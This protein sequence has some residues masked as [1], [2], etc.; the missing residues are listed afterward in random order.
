MTGRTLDHY[1][2]LEQIGI[3]GAGEVYRAIDE[4][5]GCPVAI[6]MPILPL[7][8]GPMHPDRLRQEGRVLASLRHPNICALRGAGRCDGVEY[9]VMELLEGQTLRAWMKGRPL[10]GPF[11][12]RVALQTARALAAA[13]ARRVLHGDLKPEN[14]FITRQGVVKVLDFGLAHFVSEGSVA[15]TGPRGFGPAPS[16]RATLSVDLLPPHS[17]FGTFAYMSP[18]QARGDAIDLRSD[19]FSLG[20]VLY[21][22][23]AGRRPFTGRTWVDTLAS[24]LRDDPPPMSAIG[25]WAHPG[26]D[27][28]VRRCLE[29]DP[30]ERWGC[31]SEITALLE[32]LHSG[33]ALDVR[34]SRRVHA[35]RTRAAQCR[36]GSG[37]KACEAI[38]GE[39]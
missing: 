32:R 29:K 12:L 22:M 39:V 26:I 30:A 25:R 28:I 14:V 9:L 38:H 24:I 36:A 19:L 11:L 31:A 20:V 3:G 21:E 15:P 13:H 33:A 37:G 16:Q 23:A 7:R 5:S 2:V 17:P 18:E 34:S 35:R 10:P 1:R 6:K 27:W 8:S 4:R